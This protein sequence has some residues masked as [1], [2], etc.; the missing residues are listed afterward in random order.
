MAAENKS[1][2]MGHSETAKA[3]PQLRTFGGEC[4]ADEADWRKNEKTRKP[5]V[6]ITLSTR[7]QQGTG[8]TDE[9]CKT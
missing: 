3:W 5:A 6:I 1:D 8:N 9:Q 2:D 7:A 4:E